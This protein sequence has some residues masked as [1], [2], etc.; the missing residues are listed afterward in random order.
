VAANTLAREAGMT[1]LLQPP[2]EDEA[3]RL[4]E[5]RAAMA[6]TR[7]LAM[8]AGPFGVRALVSRGVKLPRGRRPEVWPLPAATLRRVTAS[9]ARALS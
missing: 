2:M 6:R 1:V 9:L 7:A 3:R 5:A 8:R 4:A